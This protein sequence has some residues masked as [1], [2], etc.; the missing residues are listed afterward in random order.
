MILTQDADYWIR[1]GQLPILDRLGNAPEE[2]L[3]YVARYTDAEYTPVQT[4]ITPEFLVDVRAAMAELPSVVLELLDKPLL[5]VYFGRGLGSSAVTDVIAGPDG[6][7]L[8][9]VTLMDDAAFLQRSANE[10]ASWKE[11]TPFLPGSAYQLSLQIEASENDN[12]KNAI[13]FLLL[14]EFGHVLTAHSEFLPDWWI[15]AQKF[16]ASE[17][18]TFLSLCWQI[19]MNGD[20]IPLL[21]HDFAHRKELRFYSKQQV[22]GDLILAIYQ[23]LEKTGFPS[24]YAATNAYDDFAE[25]FAMYVHAVI[26]GKPYHLTVASGD[27]II[28]DIGDYW[29]SPRARA[30]KQLFAEYLGD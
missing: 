9:L 1:Q 27:Q 24:L 28:M 15:G 8:G 4:E 22:S 26:M 23:A 6:Q 3:S 14:H 29:S 7:V 18:Y 13:Q 19:A 21:R 11:S 30:K 20:I 25:S 10:W 16:K 12:R 2:L 5:G 17:E